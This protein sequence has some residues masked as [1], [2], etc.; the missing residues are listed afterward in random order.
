MVDYWTIWSVSFAKK[1]WECSILFRPQPAPCLPRTGVFFWISGWKQVGRFLQDMHACVLS[2]T[3]NF[4]NIGQLPEYMS[5]ISKRSEEEEQNRIILWLH[6]RA[7]G[8]TICA[9]HELYAIRYSPRRRAACSR[10]DPFFSQIKFTM[11]RVQ[12]GPLH[13]T[14]LYTLFSRL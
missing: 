14:L 8:D 3:Y 13:T 6:M 11:T 10:H 9:T 7:I 4:P 5:K 1:P 2:A 12:Q